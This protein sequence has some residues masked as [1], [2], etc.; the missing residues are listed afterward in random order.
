VN[1]DN[2]NRIDDFILRHGHTD[3]DPRIAQELDAIGSCEIDPLSSLD[4][5]VNARRKPALYAK[6]DYASPRDF[7]PVSQTVSMP[8]LLVVHPAVKAATLKELLALAKVRPGESV[9]V[10]KGVGAEVFA[11][12]VRR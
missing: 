3:L 1:A 10:E 4:V 7:A 8:Q 12:T 5:G 11:G 9:P 2:V 6:L